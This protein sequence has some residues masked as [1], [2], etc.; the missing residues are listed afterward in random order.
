MIAA[1]FKYDSAFAPSAPACDGAPAVAAVV[2]VHA[3]PCVWP[4]VTDMASKRLCDQIYPWALTASLRKQRDAF[5]SAS[6]SSM[7]LAT[8]FRWPMTSALASKK[9]SER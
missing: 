4:D 9:P 7:W 2:S 1:R 6:G 8:F 5:T 3:V